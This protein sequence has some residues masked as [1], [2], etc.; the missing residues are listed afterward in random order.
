MEDPPIEYYF[1]P[2]KRKFFLWF[3]LVKLF[4]FSFG[5]GSI[6]IHT[7]P[8]IILLSQKVVYLY[9]YIIYG[10][11]CHLERPSCIYGVRWHTYQWCLQNPNYLPKFH[12]AQS[13]NKTGSFHKKKVNNN[14]GLSLDMSARYISP[15]L[16]VRN[17]SPNVDLTS[18]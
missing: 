13:W 1:P 18:E 12:L 7:T 14:T 4:P 8:Y 17:C 11:K 3:T 6:K 15:W 2:S 10:S 9:R 5:H 16:A